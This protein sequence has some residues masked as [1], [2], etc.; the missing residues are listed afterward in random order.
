[1]T[2]LKD[3]IYCD[4]QPKLHKIGEVVEGA[5][6]INQCISIII[7]TI[8]GSVPLRPTFGSDVHKYIDY[9]VSEAIPNIIRECTDAISEWETRINIENITVSYIE[10]LIKIKI[11]WSL[12]V[13]KKITGTTEV[14]I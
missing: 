9:P 6:D 1:M 7:T 14:Q 4:W 12:R 10:S 13:E 5:D 11:Q 8:K 3:I 2:T